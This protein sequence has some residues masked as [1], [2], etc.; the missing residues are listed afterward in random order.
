MLRAGADE[1]TGSAD[2]ARGARSLSV[3]PRLRAPGGGARTRRLGPLLVDSRSRGFVALLL[4]HL[5]VP[6][7]AILCVRR[8]QGLEQSRRQAHGALTQQLRSL[9]EDQQRLRAATATLASALRTP[10]VRG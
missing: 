3:T 2:P 5:L 4:R 10:D 6:G 8:V 9:T 7:C 1:P